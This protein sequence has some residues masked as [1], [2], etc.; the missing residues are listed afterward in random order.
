M[1]PL[2][3][4]GSPESSWIGA[5]G[6][7]LAA[8]RNALLTNSRFQFWATRFPLTQRLAN[9][10]ARAVFDLVAG[11]VYSQILL[12]CVQ[13][14]VFEYL[15]DGPIDSITLAGKIGLDR[16]ATERLLDAAVSLRLVERRNRHRFGLG[17]LGA[18]IV[19]N[20][21]IRAMIEHHAMVY[22]DLHD[23]V[24]LLRGERPETALAA[25]WPYAG[26]ESPNTL[27]DDRVAAYTALMSASQPLVTEEIL[28]AYSFSGHRRLL[29]VGGGDG[30]FLSAVGKRYPH[31]E[32]L[33]FDLPAVAERARARFANIG[34]GDRAQAFGGDFLADPLPGGVDAISL[35]RVIHDHDDERVRHILAAARDAISPGGIVV[36]AEPM[37][38]TP[39]A[40][41]IGDAY[42][43]FYLLAMGRGRAR[44]PA[45]LAHLLIEAGFE[46]PRLIPTRIPLQTSL[47]IARKGVSDAPSAIKKSS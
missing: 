47:M 41:P 14:R 21:A 23:P 2:V 35:V 15:K 34:L 18:P 32:L 20:V 30:T 39:G 45:R 1:V 26:A 44:S 7:W 6:D 13:L 19:G 27:S 24:A 38:A 36:I 9:R 29:D 25:Y 43:G 10:R 22:R 5:V 31:L 8:C 33:L 42:F 16:E 40:E 17:P 12:A 11:F 4:S 37:A 28:D 46:A 3:S